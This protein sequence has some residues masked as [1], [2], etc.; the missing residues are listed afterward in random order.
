MEVHF[1]FALQVRYVTRTEDYIPF[2]IPME[3]SVNKAEVKEYNE[4]KAAAESTGQKFDKVGSPL[5]GFFRSS[6]S[7]LC[8]S[9]C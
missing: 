3:A 7:N 6:P 9:L 2:A 4:K 1:K 5:L 8:F